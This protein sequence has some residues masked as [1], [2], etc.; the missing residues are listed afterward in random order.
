MAETDE[1]SPAR[2]L[3]MKALFVVGII[4]LIIIIGFA[5]LII[6]PRIVGGIGGAA[7]A[8]TS[9]FRGAAG[10]GI[11][12][13]ASSAQVKTGEKFTISWE[14]EEGTSATDYVIS[15]SC[16]DD[17]SVSFDGKKATC[18]KNVSISG[19][20]NE[21]EVLPTFTQEDDY[22][23]TT[24]EIVALENGDEVRTG[25]VVVTVTNGDV[26]LDDDKDD[27]SD[28]EDKD[29][30]DGTYD[31]KNSN[32]KVTTKSKTTVTASSGKANLAIVNLRM[33]R[34]DEGVFFEDNRID[35]G[36]L[37]GAAFTVVNDGGTATGAWTLNYTEPVPGNTVRGA[38]VQPSIPAGGA[39]DYIIS[40]PSYGDGMRS[41]T[42]TLDPSN[43]VSE[44]NENDNSSTDT[45]T[46]EESSTG[47]IG[48]GSYDKNA[49]ADLR[50]TIVA[51]GRLD[52]R[53]FVK[54]NNV[55]ADDEVAI[56][57]RIAN[58]GGESTGSWRFEVR[59]SGDDSDTF[60]SARQPSLQP[61]QIAEYVIG[62]DGIDNDADELDFR[63]EADSDDDVDEE[64]E[65]NN[66]D[67]EEVELD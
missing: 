32:V 64:R 61:G 7:S 13:T 10:D 55:D 60:R 36:E 19:S 46:F 49:D 43:S 33:G 20:D 5:L 57:F 28:D 6:V 24:F 30:D 9:F 56:K 3:L 11:S 34:W 50:T 21:I 12:V 47:Q 38:G 42:V 23:D 8:L 62:F 63:V 66:T 53:S 65:N 54:T 26:D 37:G 17:L 67:T 48:G 25:K 45:I 31:S 58:I 59:M 15:Y 16:E 22:T 14:D 29:E 35:E 18:D 2:S 40:F 52:G 4:F 51:T 41:T 1:Q 27:D 44:R 39:L